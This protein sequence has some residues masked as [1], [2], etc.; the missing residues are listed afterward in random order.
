MQ[1]INP[2]VKIA[3]L[4]GAI[5]LTPVIASAQ[6]SVSL[7]LNWMPE[8]DHA[9]VYFAKQAGWYDEAGLDVSIEPGQGSG[10]SSQ[11]VGVGSYELGIAE[12]GTAF[13]AKGQGA[14]LKAVMALYANSPFTLY[15]KRSSGIEG[16]EDFEGR[17]V[18]NPPADAARVLWPAFAQAVGLSEDGVEFVNVSAAAK[19]P[20]LMADRIDI[21][22]DFYYGHDIKVRELGDDL[23]YVRWSDIGLNPYGNAFIV[24]GSYL[25][26]NPDVV[27]RFVK[28]TQRAYAACVEEPGP[29]IDALVSNASGIDP[30]VAMN[31]W[32]RTKELMADEFTTTNG[33]GY[34]DAGRMDETYEL[35]DRYLG[36]DQAFAAQDAY[37]NEYLDT[38]VLMAAPR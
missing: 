32:E 38:N 25:S 16:P 6:D 2:A 35:V 20:T 24:N 7:V 27:A 19:L 13:V 30:E 33:L 29:C 15:W 10:M 17:T 21:I 18:G 22:S 8:G 26:E 11:N 34:F 37:T 9:P 28:V 3:C 36:I 31:Q 4:A 12:L 23:G 1:R 5:L 14:D